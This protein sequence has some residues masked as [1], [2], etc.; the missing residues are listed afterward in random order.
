M[1]SASLAEPIDPHALFE[2]RCGQ[3]HNRAGDLAR[4]TLVIENG[5][6]VSKKNGR[7]LLDFLPG[8][9]GKLTDDEI[10]VLREVFQ[11]QV[12]SGGLSQEKCRHC[13]EPARIL[14]R[15]NLILY[16]GGL[17]GRHTGDDIKRV[18][19]CHGRM[20]EVEQAIVYDML[21]WHL[22]KIEGR[23]TDKHVSS[24]SLQKTDIGGIR[25]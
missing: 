16:D 19:T 14:A 22:T 20:I 17:L 21:V 1:A 11:R 5:E 9:F 10:S 15:R 2:T 3:C 8:H 7:R 4:Q 25:S 13:H 18:L 12:Q 24:D 23:D 6:L